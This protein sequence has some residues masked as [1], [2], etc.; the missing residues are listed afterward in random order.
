MSRIKRAAAHL[1][2]SDSSAA[3][4]DAD[5][6]A[7]GHT[8]GGKVA[9]SV[10]SSSLQ[11]PGRGGHMTLGNALCHNV[12]GLCQA[13]ACQPSST[14]D[15]TPSR[16][17]ESRRMRH[18]GRVAR[19]GWLRLPDLGAT[20]IRLG[21]LKSTPRPLHSAVHRRRCHLRTR[22]P[23]LHSPLR[24]LPNLF[25]GLHLD[26]LR[27]LLRGWSCHAQGQHCR[28]QGRHCVLG[29]QGPGRLQRGQEG[30]LRG[31]SLSCLNLRR[32]PHSQRLRP[33]AQ[34]G[35]LLKSRLGRGCQPSLANREEGAQE[36]LL[37][38]FGW[39]RVQCRAT[40]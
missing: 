32:L 38:D 14:Y 31:R 8:N 39:T 12:R 6:N 2:S 24:L 28:L 5:R 1:D 16:L 15:L 23:R 34:P 29:G 22:G 7:T 9:C 36:S 18:P 3:S 10:A 20:L 19:P 17:T 21:D 4:D 40:A 27:R 25:R 30:R 13:D 33:G 11:G 26:G 35:G 37:T